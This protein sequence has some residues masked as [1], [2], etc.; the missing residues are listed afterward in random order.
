MYVCI[1]T[2][3]L[4]LYLL[5]TRTVHHHSR[6]DIILVMLVHILVGGQKSEVT[7]H[8]LIA[9]HPNMCVCCLPSASLGLRIALRARLSLLVLF[10]KKGRFTSSDRLERFLE[11]RRFNYGELYRVVREG[12]GRGTRSSREVGW[13]GQAQK[14][15]TNHHR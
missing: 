10:E 15:E 6:H 8:A 14:A 13:Q 9:L 5:I 7:S 3:E 2:L 12:V 11:Y 1:R 4:S